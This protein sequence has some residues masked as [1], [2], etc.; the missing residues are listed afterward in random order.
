M[1]VNSIH[2]ID[3]YNLLCRG[4]LIK[5]K[6]IKNWIDREKN[7]YTCYLY[8]SS[9]D[10]GIYRSVWNMPGPWSVKVYFNNGYFKLAPL[11]KIFF[12]KNDSKLDKIISINYKDDKQFK[13]GLKLQTVEFLKSLKNNK[14]NLPGLVTSHKLMN[15]IHKI[16][17][18]K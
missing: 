8:F 4:K 7:I 16:Y 6:N 9:G 3:Y 10:L 12:R 13:P 11:E 5:I 17:R 1:Y 15:L 18:N 14:N 2:L